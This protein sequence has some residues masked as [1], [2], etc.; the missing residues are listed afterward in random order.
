MLVSACLS[1][2]TG[3]G[4]EIPHLQNQMLLSGSTNPYILF[5]T[6]ATSMGSGSCLL[7]LSPS[8][9]MYYLNELM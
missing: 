5:I 9:T 8:S 3:E 1:S 6:G 2:V 4:A 7:D